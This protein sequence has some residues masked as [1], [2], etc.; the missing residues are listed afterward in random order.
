MQISRKAQAVK[1]SSTLAISAKAKELKAKGV[2]LIDFSVGEPDFP[3]PASVCAAGEAAIAQGRTKYTATPGVLPLRQ[4]ISGR[5]REDYGLEIAPERIVVT[6]GAKHA[7]YLALL[8][9][10][11]PGDEVLIPAPYWVSY[12][13]QTELC[14]GVPVILPTTREAGFKVTPAA[15]KAALT[16][17]SRV[18]IL[19]SPSNPTGAVYT[20]AELE[21]LAEV[22][23]SHPSLVVLC[24]DIYEKLLYDG[25]F[26]SFSQ[27]GPAC[28]ARSVIINGVSKSAAMT[29]WRIGYAAATDDAFIKAVS[30]MQGQMTSHA[31]SIAQEAAVAALAHILPEQAAWVAEFRRRRDRMVELF[32]AVPGLHIDPPSGAFYCFVDWRELL[33]RTSPDGRALDGDM[34]WADY[35]LDH[36]AVASVPGSGFGLPGYLRFSFA[37]GYADLERGLARL[38]AAVAATR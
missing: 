25:V 30:R 19:N 2:D 9:L 37:L 10:L 23:L 20:R 16:P 12:P 28:L 13:A 7:I 24:D 21:A 17:R 5:F 32:R 31:T 36:A 33:G 18:L 38:A 29:G 1:P 14:D 26:T 8:T 3:T 22:V 35:L 34:A 6:A 11:D 15:L 27:L 4:A